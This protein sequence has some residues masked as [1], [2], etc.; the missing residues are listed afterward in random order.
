MTYDTLY[1]LAVQAVT[2]PS[3][4][5]ADALDVLA[6]ALLEEGRI[7]P[8]LPRMGRMT[9]G[10]NNHRKA[11]ET[12]VARRRAAA[13]KWARETTG[14]VLDDD[15]WFFSRDNPSALPWATYATAEDVDRYMS[16]A[17]S[18]KLNPETPEKPREN[19]P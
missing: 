6:D 10:S 17:T 14:F 13:F 11:V 16:P 15:V 9:H 19:S 5:A 12:G 18:L 2:T 1:E 7:K 4:G 3:L 8:R